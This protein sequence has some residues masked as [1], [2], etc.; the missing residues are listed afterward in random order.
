MVCFLNGAKNYYSIYMNKFLIKMYKR[1]NR[2]SQTDLKNDI[3]KVDVG[4][5]KNI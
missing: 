5:C 3:I 2:H 4:L 1:K